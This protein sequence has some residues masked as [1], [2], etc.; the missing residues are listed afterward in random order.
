[1]EKYVH[2]RTWCASIFLFTTRRLIVLS[3]DLSDQ[4]SI[5]DPTEK[6]GGLSLDEN[7]EVFAI[8]NLHVAIAYEKPVSFAT[9]RRQVGFIC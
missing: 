2:A 5:D 4:E 8:T 9:T 6:F 1:M 3:L 7:H